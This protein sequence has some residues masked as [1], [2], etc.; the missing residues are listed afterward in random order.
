MDIVGPI[1]GEHQTPYLIDLYSRWMEV[2]NVAEVATKNVKAFLDELFKERY[3]NSILTDNGPQF[4][5]AEFGDYLETGEL[6]I[7]EVQF[8]ILRQTETLKV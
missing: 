5:S 3:L 4:A 2:M 1:R 7:R 8:I 6:Y